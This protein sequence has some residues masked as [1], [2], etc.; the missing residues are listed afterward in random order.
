MLVELDLVL[1]AEGPHA[2]GRGAVPWMRWSLA[3]ALA[4]G[5]HGAVMGSLGWK[6][7]GCVF[8]AA[9]VPLLLLASTAV[10][11]PFFFA[12]NAALGL[13]RDFS[14]ALRAILAAQAALAIC[15]ASLT[16]VLLLFYWSALSYPSALL[17]NAALFAVASTAGQI[18]LRRHYSPLI[19]RQ[20]AHRIGLGAWFLLHVF[21]SVKMAWLLRP[22]VGDPALPTTFFRAGAL[23]ENPYVILLWTVVGLARRVLQ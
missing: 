23:D 4:G 14:A 2:V 1:R 11:L 3:L 17:L 21:L 16:P 7:V 6:G 15:L 18:S 13:R 22:F 9:K 5:V 8:S 20:P 10:C 12:L 19:A